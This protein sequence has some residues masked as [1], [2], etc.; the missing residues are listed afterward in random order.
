MICP[1]CH[2]TYDGA[3]KHCSFDGAELSDKPRIDHVQVGKT[4]HMGAIL[5]DRFEIKGF[6]GQG[7]TSRVYLALDHRTQEPVALKLLEPPWAHDRVARERFMQEAEAAAR[8]HH[9]GV[10]R[11]IFVGQRGNGTPFIAMEFLYGETLRAFLTREVRME[12]D[13]LLPV[14]RELVATLEIAHLAGVIH[15]DVKPENV[16]LIGDLGEPYAV[17]LVD[18]GF[19][20]L[21]DSTITAAGIAIGSVEYMAP[22]QCVTDTVDARTDVYGVGTLMFKAVTGRLPFAD[23]PVEDILAHNLIAPAPRLITVAD[24]DPFLSA[25]VEKCLRKDP[26]NRYA[27][28]GALLRDLDA[29]AEGHEPEAANVEAP[30]DDHYLPKGPFAQLAAKALYRRLNVPMPHDLTG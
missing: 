25:V 6:L 18:F 12:L 27:S 17:K 29:V 26:H 28:M 11:I 30:P 2:R 13:L 1:R 3:E 10:A 19:A 23:A 20:K 5:G 16:F 9:P 7:G 21:R 4:R 8:I 22:E 24:V 15:R 14:L